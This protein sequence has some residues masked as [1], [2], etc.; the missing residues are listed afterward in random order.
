MAKGIDVSQY[1]GRIDFTKVKSSEITFAYIRATLGSGVIDS[2]FKRNWEAA[3]IVDLPRGA[4]HFLTRE[5]AQVQ[6]KSYIATVGDVRRVDLKPMLD[7]E[8]QAALVTAATRKEYVH[9]ARIFIEEVESA[10][11][12]DVILYTGGPFFNALAASADSSD[13]D[14]ITDRELWLAAYVTNPDKYVPKAWRDKGKSWVFHQLSGD[15][16]ASGGP[17]ARVNG[18]TTVVDMNTTQGVAADIIEWIGAPTMRLNI[19]P[20]D[21]TYVTSLDEI[22]GMC[23]DTT[24]EVDEGHQH[25]MF[26]ILHD[27][28]HL[29]E[30]GD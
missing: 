11:G 22:L 15:V 17:G 26:G 10:T 9:G 21:P 30:E 13:V 25:G 20:M 3:R 1:Q 5:N 28:A 14:F 6:A 27:V 24:P 4:Y 12:R 19:P 23:E 7:V 29:M 8:C 18:I 16:D 2:Q